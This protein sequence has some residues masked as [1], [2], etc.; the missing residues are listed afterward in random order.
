MPQADELPAQIPGLKTPDLRQLPQVFAKYPDILAVYLFGSAVTGR[1]HKESDLDLAIV[2]RTPALRE[3]MLD[4]LR[5]LTEFGLDDVS[6]VF[7][8]TKDIVFKHEVVRLNRVIYQTEDFERGAYFSLIT[9]Q[10][11][12]F[13]PYLE[14]QRKAYKRRILGD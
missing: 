11:L 6:L 7:L 5:D 13:L 8:D 12:D 9:R 3:K 4:I 10:Y 14:R 1:V 2:P